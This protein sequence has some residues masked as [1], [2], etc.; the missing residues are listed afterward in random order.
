MSAT[1]TVS[2]KPCKLCKKKG[3]LCHVH[4][5]SPKKTPKKT[6]LKSGVRAT[7][8]KAPKT[9]KKTPKKTPARATVV[10]SSKS[11]KKGIPTE[12]YYLEQ[13]PLPVL[14][15]VMMNM[16][17]RELN[18]LCNISRRAKKICDSVRFREDY[19]KT[20]YFPFFFQGDVEES[21][22]KN[23]KTW[24]LYDDYDHRMYIRDEDIVITAMFGDDLIMNAAA[25]RSNPNNIGI[26][27]AYNNEE[28]KRIN[29]YIMDWANEL[30]KTKKMTYFDAFVEI[31]KREIILVGKIRGKPYK[32]LQESKIFNP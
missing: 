8:V 5:S 21:Y 22:N 31:I 3:D 11:P 24:T 28:G 1:G 2:G 4:A 10:K 26:K 29:S 20:H 30:K 18:R 27:Q 13:L 23:N 16:E 17:H 14:E 19:P 6:P 9:P 15:V 32:V 12:F 25:A 7:A